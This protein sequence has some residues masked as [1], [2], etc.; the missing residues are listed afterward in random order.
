MFYRKLFLGLLW[1]RNIRSQ[2]FWLSEFSNI[3]LAQKVE[4]KLW[5]ASIEIIR[6]FTLVFEVIL[7]LL[8]LFCPSAQPLFSLWTQKYFC[9]RSF[10]LESNPLMEK[11]HWW[12]LQICSDACVTLGFDASKLLIFL[13]TRK[14]LYVRYK[15]VFFQFFHCFCLVL[16]DVKIVRF[17]V[18]IRDIASI[19]KNS[20]FENLSNVVILIEWFCFV[21]LLTFE[22]SDGCG[23]IF[24]SFGKHVGFWSDFE[25]AFTILSF[26]SATLQSLNSEVFL[27]LKLSSWIQPSDGEVSLVTA[28]DLLRGL[29]DLGF[30]RQQT[31]QNPKAFNNT[32]FFEE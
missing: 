9:F 4:I 20:F 11:F 18:L 5:K 23:K 7:E 12:L 21:L 27:F 22:V 1:E 32:S 2:I 25:A 30:W 26:R 16:F 15:T 8:L 10:H 6:K 28:T 24:T 19:V 13:T 14:T 29:R 31:S 3:L 17:T